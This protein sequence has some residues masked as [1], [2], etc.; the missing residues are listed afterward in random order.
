M[1]AP[2]NNDDPSSRFSF[3]DSPQ[4][5]ANLGASANPQQ[6]R[7]PD[8]N[9]QVEGETLGDQIV[10]EVDDALGCSNRLIGCSFWLL[11][12][13]FRVVWKVIQAVT[14]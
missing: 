6:Q 5:Q 9:R 12:L 4:G 3:D 7:R 10:D 2:P 8:R 1:A 11:T 13:P 14:D